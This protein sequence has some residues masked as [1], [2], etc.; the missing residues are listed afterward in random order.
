VKL[1]Y[2]S[3]LITVK[4]S[5]TNGSVTN[6][7]IKVSPTPTDNVISYT[8]I[9]FNLGDGKYV[10]VYYKA[11]PTIGFMVKCGTNNFAI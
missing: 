3:D 10:A 6:E 8:P 1:L 5:H 2:P 9:G 11:A 7:F 4:F